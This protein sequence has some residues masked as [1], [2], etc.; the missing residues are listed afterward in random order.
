MKNEKLRNMFLAGLIIV[1]ALTVAACGAKQ[2]SK[3]TGEEEPAVGE[4]AEKID[5][6]TKEVKMIVPSGAGSVPDLAARAL[7]EGFKQETGQALVVENIAGG[8][9]VPGTVA[10]V[11]SA[12][13][14]YTIGIL[15]SGVLNLRPLLQQ[16]EYSFPEDFTPII[17]VGDYQ[18]NF[19]AQKDAPY[20][21]VAE[22]IQY[23][24]DKNEKL[25]LAT[26][27]VN[28]A[29]HLVMELVAKET[30]VQYNHLPSEDGNKAVIALLGGHV[31]VAIVNLADI[32]GQLQKGDVKLL[33]VPAEER[34]GNLPDVLTLKEQGID[35]VGAPMFAIYGPKN[36][37]PEIAEKLYDV[38]LKSMETTAFQQYVTNTSLWVTKTPPN[39]LMMQLEQGQKDF[40]QVISKQQ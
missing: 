11:N 14:G 16:V 18:I 25:K 34:Y 10:L 3:T 24:K 28:T 12:S 15:P 6:P 2:G 30:G 8:A 23:Y 5:Y 20:N 29:S 32:Y 26:S 7:A 4:T 37:P 33:G 19:V 1:L 21:T 31:D 38:F 35:V 40:E 13:D 39:A 9:Q 36:L 27:G 22:M 17:G